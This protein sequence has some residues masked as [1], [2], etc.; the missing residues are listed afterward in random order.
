MAS[1]LTPEDEQLAG[2][3]RATRAI[4]RRQ[5]AR[6]AARDVAA[7]AAA[8]VE[9]IER[10]RLTVVPRALV[11]ELKRDPA[12][13]FTIATAQL[14]FK[15]LRHTAILRLHEAGCGMDEIRSLT[16]HADPHTVLAHYLAAS[17]TIAGAALARRL[18][19]EARA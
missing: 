18:A 2:A 15:N 14:Q 5:Q 1:E 13:G 7:L 17:T 16:G 19:G 3:A 12:A 4:Y 6:Q 11:A 9:R 10:F 8:G